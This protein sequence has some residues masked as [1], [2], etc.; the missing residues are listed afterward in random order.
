MSAD[1]TIIGYMDKVA[2]DFEL[3]KAAGGRKVYTSVDGLK[4][5]KACWEECGIVEVEVRLRSV[6]E[7]GTI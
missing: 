5:E 3:G 2:F 6:V 4:A 7:Q 1:R